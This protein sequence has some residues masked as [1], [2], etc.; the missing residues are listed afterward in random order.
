MPEREYRMLKMPYAIL[1][2]ELKLLDLQKTATILAKAEG[3][4]YAD[5]TRAVRNCCGILATDLTLQEAK[6]ICNELNGE[7]VGVF[8]MEQSK[9]Y[10]PA[11]AMVVN[12]GD[13]L[14]DGF[15]AQDMYGRS[16]PLD[17]AN[18]ILISLGRV[19]ERKEA[20][21][22][23]GSPTRAA[24]RGG[25]IVVAALFGG[26]LAAPAPAGSSSRRK[27]TEEEDFV[28]DIFSKEP[29]ERH[30]R[31]K[32]KGFNYD[33]LGARLRPIAGENFH[34]LVEDLVRF[35]TQAYGNRGINAFLSGKEP[36]KLNYSDLDHFDRENL[37]L[38]Q[39]IHCQ[40]PPA[41]EK[42]AQT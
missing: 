21:T 13:C 19:V 33:Y 39:L 34:F 1:L 10:F 8:Y 23:D 41:E 42:K 31:I 29:Q 15:H 9:M 14:E 32:Q 28:L 11:S 38:L 27:I 5:A 6:T 4:I 26:A 20:V 30:Y 3:I 37:W 2:E 16:Y 35:A 12:N 22:Y 18:V 17:W 40:T 25:G 36:E 24:I 7:G